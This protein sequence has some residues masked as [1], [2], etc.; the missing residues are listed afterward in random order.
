MRVNLIKKLTILNYV[1]KHGYK[2]SFEEWIS[3]LKYADWDSPQDIIHTFNLADLLGKGCHRIVFNIAGNN[4][5]MI[6]KYRFAK[7]R[8][9]KR[10]H[11]YV[12]WIGDHK[13]YDALCK[14][15]LQYTINEY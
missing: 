7:N 11:L 13:E 8:K 9:K 15:S 12:C 1:Q 6:C 4:C 10:V 3:K 14:S 5:R 2:S